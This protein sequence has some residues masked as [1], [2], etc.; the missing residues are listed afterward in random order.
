MQW[1]IGV[2]VA[3]RKTQSQHIIQI[4]GEAVP[5]VVRR[6]AQARRLILRL[7]EQGTGA[8]VTI[9]KYANFQDGVDMAARKADW[10]K[11]Q[12]A[13][14]CGSVA[15]AD[16]IELPFL[17]APHVVRHSPTGRGVRRIGDVEIHV[18]GREEHLNRRLTDWLKAQA[19]SEI[20]ARAHEKAAT[21][22]RRINRITI[23]D[24]RSRWG[25]CGTGGTLNF[26]WRLVLAP[27]HVL[28]YVVAHEVAHLVHHNHG[29]QFWA[30]TDSLTD[31]PAGSMDEA[32]DWL[33]AFGRDL[34]RYG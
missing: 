7:N 28:D 21:V 14:Q 22:E 13:K 12:L 34:H 8:V 32:R 11:R 24:T 29:E 23:R 30:L 26:S 9:P 1:K 16:G 20:S 31:G 4:D 3:V 6:H 27:E 33:S 2:R 10:I 19:R 25:S 5:L 17:G 15:F 18:A